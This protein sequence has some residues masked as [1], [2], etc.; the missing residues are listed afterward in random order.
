M[1]VSITSNGS[2]NNKLYYGNNNSIGYNN[3]HNTYNNIHNTL[4][5]NADFDM[6]QR[7][8]GYNFNKIRMGHLSALRLKEVGLRSFDDQYID[9][10]KNFHLRVYVY[11]KPIKK[12]TFDACNNKT[13]GD[14]HANG[15][16]VED[17]F[18]LNEEKFGIHSTYNIEDYTTPLVYNEE[19]LN[20]YNKSSLIKN[21]FKQSVQNSKNVNNYTINNK[22]R[23]EKIEASAANIPLN[24]VKENYHNSNSND[25]RNKGSNNKLEGDNGLFCLKDGG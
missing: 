16:S 11:Y 3:L 10:R 20:K 15:W 5:K 22:W 23:C 18:K 7:G 13:F 12:K 14:N 24:L 2:S 17:M 25:N 4:V 1:K 6:Y 8:Y 9:K 19:C 21:N